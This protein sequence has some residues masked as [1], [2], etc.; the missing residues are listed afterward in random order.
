MWFGKLVTGAVGGIL[1]SS[2]GAYAGV[3][4]LVTNGS[5]EAPVVSGGLFQQFT[6]GVPGWSGSAGI[7]VQTNG[8]L[9]TGQGTPFGNQY[10]ELGVEQP[11]TY[12]QALSTIPGTTYD[13]SFYLSAR[14]GTGTNTVSVG[15]TG[16]ASKNFSA[17]DSG[18][19]NFEKFAGTFVAT[20][21]NSVLSFTPVNLVDPG[22]GDLLDNVSV[23][24]STGSG[25]AAVP[26]P[27]ALWSGFIGLTA[28]TGFWMLRKATRSTDHN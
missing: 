1:L 13:Y 8:I 2:V 26:L 21:A 16:N 11:S 6:S 12:S 24:A 14:P 23:T 27:P 5:F 9:G 7:E 19:V 20:G 25:S 17:P 15:L 4:D 28:I 18:S 10:A 3:T 22:A